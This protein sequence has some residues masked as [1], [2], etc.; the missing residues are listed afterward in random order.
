[1]DATLKEFTDRKN[2]FGGSSSATT[3]PTRASKRKQAERDAQ[4]QEEQAVHPPKRTRR[5][6]PGPGPSTASPRRTSRVPRPTTRIL[7]ATTQEDVKP[8]RKPRLR[9]KSSSRSKRQSSVKPRSSNVNRTKQVFD[10]VE[11][12]M[13]TRPASLREETKGKGKQ[14]DVD[15]GEEGGGEPSGEEGD[16]NEQNAREYSMDS[17][18]NKGARR[19]ATRQYIRGAS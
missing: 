1:M 10:G 17:G 5:S 3:S 14:D 18:S 15:E 12:P 13:R 9:R 6:D 8:K 19:I 4:V 11:I 16:E 2:G 7:A